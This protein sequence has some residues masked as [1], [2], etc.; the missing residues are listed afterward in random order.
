[1]AG[2]GVC[3][4]YAE[5]L[6]ASNHLAFGY[7][8][9][10]DPVRRTA[11][12][13]SR[14]MDAITLSGKV[15][16]LPENGLDARWGFLMVGPVYRRDM[17]VRNTGECRAALR[18]YVHISICDKQF[19]DSIFPDGIPGLNLQIFDGL[20]TTPDSLLYTHEEQRGAR[21]PIPS[22]MTVEKT[23]ALYG[24]N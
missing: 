23:V 4:L 22:A 19:I 11:I 21:L 10:S 9:F 3:I 1:M 7:D 2:G 8:M 5:P 17:L 16:L 14:D 18:G 15:T 13:R 24:R 20:R 12:E 6:N